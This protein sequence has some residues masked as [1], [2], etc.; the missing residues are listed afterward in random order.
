MQ[1]YVFV[2][3]VIVTFFNF[4]FLFVCLFICFCLLLLFLFCFFYFEG[5]FIEYLCNLSSKVQQSTYDSNEH[6]GNLNYKGLR[7]S[8]WISP[9][10]TVQSRADLVCYSVV[11]TFNFYSRMLQI[12]LIQATGQDVKIVS[13]PTLPF[14]RRFIGV[15]I[16]LGRF[17]AEMAMV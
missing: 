12:L 6:V 17:T 7:Q 2:V 14:G 15:A 1:V 16:F 10:E 11:L 5:Y 9:G 13:N 8:G 3:V 4:L